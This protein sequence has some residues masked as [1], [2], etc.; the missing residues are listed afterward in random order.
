MIGANVFYLCAASIF[1]TARACCSTKLHAPRELSATCP[2]EGRDRDRR[3]CHGLRGELGLA[4]RGA[5][6]SV[7]GIC[8]DACFGGCEASQGAACFPG[9][10]EL[11]PQTEKGEEAASQSKDALLAPDG[12]PVEVTLAQG[13][14]VRGVDEAD[15]EAGE[16]MLP[17]SV[18]CHRLLTEAALHA[19]LSLDS[20][21][22][23]QALAYFT[24]RCQLG[25][26]LGLWPTASPCNAV[27][28]PA[29]ASIRV[30]SSWLN[31][32]SK[33]ESADA[34]ADEANGEVGDKP[35]G[36]K[37]SRNPNL[38]KQGIV[39][40]SRS[41]SSPREAPKKNVAKLLTG[42]KARIFPGQPAL[43]TVCE[44][45]SGLKH[46]ESFWNKIK[47]GLCANILAAK[48]AETVVTK[49]EC[50]DV[51]GEADGGGIEA[52]EGGEEADKA[53]EAD[54][55][56]DTEAAALESFEQ[57]YQT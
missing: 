41:S 16:E 30:I 19:I 11:K 36:R 43:Q 53:E 34:E 22:L 51:D 13:E 8:A 50:G 1:I 49:K 25:Y 29:G 23:G 3:A 7:P 39:A 27:T 55:A 32:K 9:M 42:L 33:K 48:I 18:L 17:P 6:E 14:A 31:K 46:H 52:D 57:W 21:T 20:K 10:V 44:L 28:T 4:D 45:G 35:D 12:V 37:S 15:E 56:G 26:R 24:R 2:Q 47:H 5:G 38:K 54:E 40:W